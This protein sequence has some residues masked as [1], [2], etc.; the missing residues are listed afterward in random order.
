[1]YELQ[2]SLADA[3]AF[4]GGLFAEG[5]DGR[6]YGWQYRT[7]SNGSPEVVLGSPDGA[8]FTLEQAIYLGV[9]PPPG[10]EVPSQEH[11]E[12][13]S[14]ATR[15]ESAALT[16]DVPPTERQNAAEAYFVDS[17]NVGYPTETSSGYEAPYETS[18]NNHADQETNGT[19]GARKKGAT[20]LSF[21]KNYAE[22]QHHPE[23]WLFFDGY[24]VAT[25]SF[26][27]GNDVARQQLLQAVMGKSKALGGLVA[28]LIR[29][30]RSV[31]RGAVLLTKASPVAL[32]VG[33]ATP[34]PGDEV[35]T[36]GIVAS[37]LVAIAKRRHAI[38]NGLL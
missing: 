3:N 23:Q 34:I 31:R 33:V 21:Y 8:F 24:G 15:P 20:A 9:S 13:A 26:I 6:W 7:D 30:P 36:V 18:E 19:N 38:K 32:P 12:A 1:M 2:P 14:A 10:C 16:P 11:S 35:L 27:R 37:V 4:I 25:A 17:T 5:E 22:R 29:S 28:P